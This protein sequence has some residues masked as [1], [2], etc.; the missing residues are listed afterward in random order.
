MYVHAHIRYLEAMAKIGEA[1]RLY[2]GLKVINPILI[3]EN[4]NNAITRQ[5]N[6]YFSSSDGVLL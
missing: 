2:H 6:M 4:V 1:D 5:S 3:Q